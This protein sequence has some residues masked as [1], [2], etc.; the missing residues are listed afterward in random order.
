MAELSWLETDGV[1][2]GV[3]GVELAL[4][5]DAGCFDFAREATGIP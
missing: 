2:V 4:W 1:R 5:R 3:A